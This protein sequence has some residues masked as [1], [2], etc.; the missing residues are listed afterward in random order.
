[1][2]P[3][4][5]NSRTTHSHHCTHPRRLLDPFPWS[6]PWLNTHMLGAL[7]WP[8][9]KK[10]AQFSLFL[11]K[12]AMREGCRAYTSMP[13]SCPHPQ[14]T[15]PLA[16]GPRNDLH[17]HTAP[18]PQSQG[19]EGSWK[20]KLVTERTSAPPPPTQPRCCRQKLFPTMES[21]C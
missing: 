9:A 21:L 17:T 15:P 5:S 19:G 2:G 7:A 1:M 4:L 20:G 8:F 16:P 6:E 10:F 11:L 14:P 3:Q 18:H 12:D 13:N